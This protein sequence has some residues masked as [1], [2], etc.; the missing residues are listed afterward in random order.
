MILTSKL[1]KMLNEILLRYPDYN[2]GEYI[3]FGVLIVD[4]R[5]SETREYIINY[6][7]YFDMQSANYFNF[8]IPGFKHGDN[9]NHCQICVRGESY[10]FD[11]N[12]FYDFCNE[13]FSRLDI[14]YTFN[15]MLILTT[16]KIMDI[17]TAEYIVIEL[18]NNNWNSVR[19]AG[20][21]FG[22]IF[23][24]ARTTPD[25][26]NIRR[27]LMKTEIKKHLLNIIIKSIDSDCLTEIAE[28]G[29]EIARYRIR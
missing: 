26:K 12:V 20:V 5:Q 17:N 15:P 2:E 9:L 16:M 14:H 1:D 13:F 8:F 19:R 7:P 6:L 22:N 4:P 21:L 11:E 27:R 25:L 28:T 29:K 10:Y 3:T 23:E 24:T 18:D